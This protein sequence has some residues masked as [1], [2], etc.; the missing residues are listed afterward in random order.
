MY[1][2]LLKLRLWI[3]VIYFDNF[4]SLLDCVPFPDDLSNL[5]KKMSRAREKNP[6][7]SDYQLVWEIWKK[8]KKKMVR[9]ECLHFQN[10]TWKIYSLVDAKGGKFS[11]NC[12]NLIIVNTLEM[13]YQKFP[14]F[15]QILFRLIVVINTSSII[16]W[17]YLFQVMETFRKET[18]KL[19]NI[20][21]EDIRWV[22]SIISWGIQ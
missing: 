13:K 21:I 16:D 14:F 12:F 19:K 8:F 3:S 7:Y 5:K 1:V 18:P 22:N 6:I 20:V 15:I 17:I 4:D 9:W 11:N 2:A 10:I